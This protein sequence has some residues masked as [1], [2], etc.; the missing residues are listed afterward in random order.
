MSENNNEAKRAM[1][2]LTHTLMAGMGGLITLLLAGAL[3]G[4]YDKIETG[5]KITREII[6]QQNM[7]T[8]ARLTL[9]SAEIKS[10]NERLQKV[11]DDVSRINTLQNIRIER[12]KARR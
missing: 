1:W 11:C 6:T 9:L 3:Y 12:E 8:Q 5:D 2:T 4:I 10:N 7:I